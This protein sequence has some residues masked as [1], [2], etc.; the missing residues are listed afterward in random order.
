MPKPSPKRP[1][2][3]LDPLFQ[4]TVERMLATPPQ[5][6]VGVKKVAKGKKKK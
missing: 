4:R 1:S 3:E 2:I 5:P 6:K